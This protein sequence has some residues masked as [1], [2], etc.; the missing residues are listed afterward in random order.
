M[1]SSVSTL[2]R[3]HSPNDIPKVYG[4]IFKYHADVFS[5]VC[6]KCRVRGKGRERGEGLKNGH[7]IH[8]ITTVMMTY[9][10]ATVK[11]NLNLCILMQKVGSSNDQSQ[12]SVVHKHIWEQLVGK[13]TAPPPVDHGV[14]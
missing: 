10:N 13:V 3:M 14:R 5:G 1:R 9:P 4:N 11:K 2:N 8:K 6:N 7:C 12:G